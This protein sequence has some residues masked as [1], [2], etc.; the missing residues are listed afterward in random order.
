M[1]GVEDDGIVRRIEDPVQRQGELDDAEIRTEMPSGCS[2][3]VNQ[4]LTDLSSQFG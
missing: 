2:H 3:L 4:E 1:T